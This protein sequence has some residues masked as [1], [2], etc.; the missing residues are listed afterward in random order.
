MYITYVGCMPIL[1][2]Y[3]MYKTAV[4]AVLL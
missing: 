3:K 4:K 1:V 2:K